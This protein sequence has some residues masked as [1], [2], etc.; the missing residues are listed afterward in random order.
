MRPLSLSDAALLAPKLAGEDAEVTDWVARSVSNG[1][2]VS[3]ATRAAMNTFMGAV[4]SAGLRSKLLRV[5]LFCGN[6]FVHDNVTSSMGA[7]Q[8]PLIKDK[9]GS[10]DLFSGPTLSW[11]YAERGA[12]GGLQQTGANWIDTTFV[13]STDFSNIND[14]G[15]SV[16]VRDGSNEA[17]VAMG[18]QTGSSSQGYILAAYSDGSSYGNIWQT[19][20]GA[21]DSAGKGLYTVSRTASNLMTLYKNGASLTSTTTPLGSLPNV[22]L[23]VFAQRGGTPTI[24]QYCTKRMGGYVIHLG[25]SASEVLSLYNAIQAF[26]T[27]LTRNV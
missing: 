7:V 13:P 14:C 15:F 27:A 12:S 20:I 9:G 26:Q 24:G 2:S 25:L 10:L 21:S 11:T 6:D 17:S 8:V 4:K 23:A 19:Q 16:Y 3:G 18:C 22:T 5:N 1:G